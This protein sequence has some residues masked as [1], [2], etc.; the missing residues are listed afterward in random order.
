MN[1]STI[2]VISCE[3]DLPWKPSHMYGQTL[4][5]PSEFPEKKKVIKHVT[6]MIDNRLWQY[7][8]ILFPQI[9][10]VFPNFGGDEQNYITDGI[11]SKS[12]IW[13]VILLILNNDLI[14]AVCYSHSSLPLCR[15]FRCQGGVHPC[16]KEHIW[17]YWTSPS[18]FSDKSWVP[19]FTK[20]VY[21]MFTQTTSVWY[22]W[23]VWI[24]LT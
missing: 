1:N 14:F 2:F 4:I 11:H 7:H 19:K 17:L 16:Q 6:W 20:S 12:I 8:S 24:W 23:L 15:D 10:L 13:A 21:H 18:W 3:W 5:K 22:S 9:Q